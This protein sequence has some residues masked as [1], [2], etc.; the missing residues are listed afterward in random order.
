MVSKDVAF[1]EKTYYYNSN[2]NL[3]RNLP[4]LQLLD[5]SVSHFCPREPTNDQNSSDLS[6][7]TP[8]SP[9]PDL[10]LRDGISLV[11]DCSSVSTH[12]ESVPVA[13]LEDL[14]TNPLA[15]G[16]VPN[17]PSSDHLPLFPKFYERRK[18][19]SSTEVLP[20]SQVPS[21]LMHC[22]MDKSFKIT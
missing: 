14:P 2:N 22:S 4:Y 7:F 8:P 3:P 13:N 6:S 12:I 19:P 20:E 21:N 10:S 11:P 17:E 9:Y 18:Q 1:D 16:S 5:T 15:V